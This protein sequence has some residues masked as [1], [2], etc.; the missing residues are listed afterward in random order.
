VVRPP[1]K[2]K[3]KSRWHSAD[4]RPPS[5]LVCGCCQPDRSIRTN[6]CF[7]SAGPPGDPK[8]KESRTRRAQRRNRP[9]GLGMQG[10]TPIRKEKSMYVE[11]NMQKTLVHARVSG[12]A[13]LQLR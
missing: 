6:R 4:R 1:A 2:E 8:L 13:D 9:A 10:G 7:P 3:P 11:K 5:L 12:A